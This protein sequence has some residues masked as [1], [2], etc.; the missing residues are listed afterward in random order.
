MNVKFSTKNFRL[1]DDQKELFEKK[2]SKFDKYFD[3]NANATV[4]LS[5]I[6]NDTYIM[7]IAI[8]VGKLNVRTTAQSDEMTKNIDIA[9]PKLERQILKHKDKFQSKV[10]KGAFE[11]PTIYEEP[12]EEEKKANVVKVKK[13]DVSVTSVDNAIEEMEI[14]DHNFYVFINGDTNKVA[15]VYKRN[16]GDYGLIEPEYK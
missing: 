1:R 2:L 3:S 7:E 5:T 15:V 9:L 14:L 13:F 10:S 16:D 4:K 11:T 12:K 6:G 8:S